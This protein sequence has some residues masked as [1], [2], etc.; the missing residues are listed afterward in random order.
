MRGLGHPIRLNHRD[1]EAALYRYLH[2]TAGGPDGLGWP[3]GRALF[4]AEVYSVLQGLDGVDVVEEAA[5]NEVNAATNELGPL[6]AS[7]S[8]PTDALVCSGQHRVTVH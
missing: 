3:F 6:V 1:A 5:L 7:I 8:P 2:P 4:V